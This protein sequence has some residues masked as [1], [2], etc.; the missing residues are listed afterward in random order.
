MDTSSR[1]SMGLPSTNEK[2]S[3][4]RS[5]HQQRLLSIILVSVACLAPTIAHTAIAS[6]FGD[7]TTLLFAS[8]S[9][10]VFLLLN[11]AQASFRFHLLR[12][13][14]SIPW[15]FEI[16]IS[17]LALASCLGLFIFMAFIL[18]QRETDLVS[19]VP[20]FGFLD[21][22]TMLH[23]VD[24]IACISLRKKEKQFKNFGG[25]IST[26]DKSIE[27]SNAL[28]QRL[29]L[30]LVFHGGFLIPSV[31]YYLSNDYLGLYLPVMIF[32]FIGAVVV[33]GL[34]GLWASRQSSPL[35]ALKMY[36]IV[37]LVLAFYGAF[38]LLM[39]IRECS[40]YEPGLHPIGVSASLL[41]LGIAS[42]MAQQSSM[43]R[44]WR[45]IK[46]KQQL[47]VDLDVQYTILEEDEENLGG[48]SKGTS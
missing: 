27:A 12:N 36:L 11:L 30:A 4:F 6:S 28:K 22:L 38:M 18:I 37:S 24:L 13:K 46:L 7:S 34:F 23:S 39:I 41:A 33:L 17:S 47:R 48:N 43:H 31:F 8:G 21:T 42:W 9:T 2:F 19:A 3:F 15:K 44:A 14:K 5:G 29:L 32:I 26:S 10:L 1:N 45:L 40:T 35:A 20:L 25:S 16:L